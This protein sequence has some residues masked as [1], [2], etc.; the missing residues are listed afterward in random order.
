MIQFGS[1]SCANDPEIVSFLKEL[2]TKTKDAQSTINTIRELI[3]TDLNFHHRLLIY[4]RMV[5]WGY[6][7]QDEAR[8]DIANRFNISKFNASS[9]FDRTEIAS[10]LGPRLTTEFANI[11]IQQ[12]IRYQDCFDA[13]YLVSKD[14][15][16]D[17]IWIYTPPATGFFSVVE[18]I[19][20]AKFL[21]TLHRKIFKL[22]TDYGKWWRY[23]VPFSDIFQDQFL[24]DDHSDSRQ[25]KYL[26]WNIARDIATSLDFTTLQA[27]ARF[28]REEYASVKRRLKNWLEGFGESISLPHESAVFFIRGGDKLVIETIPPPTHTIEI[29][30]EFLLRKSEDFMVLS[31][32]F[33]LAQNF[34][35]K[36]G[37]SKIKNITEDGL[38]G[39]FVNNMSSI[40]N[41][42]TIIRNYLIISS[43]KYSMSC[44]S[45]NLVNS[46]HWSNP[47]LKP[48]DLRS[49]PLQRYV[50][51]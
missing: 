5:F 51:L 44:P 38:N 21:C 12:A 30:C 7:T 20:L 15:D 23:P 48:I 29:D 13:E 49:T 2:V 28:K 41:V 24:D 36:F 34:S 33:K 4:V 3:K 46:A 14:Y 18:N 40:Q 6:I 50:F 19:I 31:D 22:D 10:C 16:G 17:E 45:S 26:T 9:S 11:D 25:V 35:E 1:M 43:A 39:Y 42:R 47:G 8:D 37:K 32:D 27:L